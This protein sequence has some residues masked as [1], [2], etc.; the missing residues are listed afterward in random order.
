MA[1]ASFVPYGEAVCFVEAALA[2]VA[3]GCAVEDP[4]S[5]ASFANMDLVVEVLVF[6]S[7][8]PSVFGPFGEVERALSFGNGGDV[9]GDGAVDGAVVVYD[10]EW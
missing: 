3:S 7:G 10:C 4:C 5:E 2:R 8:E 6:V 1:W 9:I